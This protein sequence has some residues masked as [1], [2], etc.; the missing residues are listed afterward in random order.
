M[1]GIYDHTMSMWSRS[2]TLKYYKQKWSLHP[3]VKYT[4]Y[5]CYAG[6]YMYMYIV[7][8]RPWLSWQL[9][10][11]R[12]ARSNNSGLLLINIPCTI[13]I[14][15][16]RVVYCTGFCPDSLICRR[17]AHYKQEQC[18]SLIPRPGNHMSANKSQHI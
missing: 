14:T 18:V 2:V 17:G 10:E 15:V 6:T 12:E 11:A 7:L 5:I 8:W 3:V 4:L 1:M 16:F 9:K 13:Y